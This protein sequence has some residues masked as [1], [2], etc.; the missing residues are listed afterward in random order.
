MEKRPISSSP[1]NLR[2]CKTS[3][4]TVLATFLE[5]LTVHTFKTRL[6][7]CL[8][9]TNLP[10]IHRHCAFSTMPKQMLMMHIRTVAKPNES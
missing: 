8:V 5:I 7:L 10:Q 1:T 3:K 4:K 6:G 2:L 9:P